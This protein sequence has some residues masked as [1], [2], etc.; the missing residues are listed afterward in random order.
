MSK[1]II[2]LFLA[3]LLPALIFVFLKYFGKNEFDI[4]VYYKD[5]VSE[6]LNGC[7]SIS[8]GQYFVPDS[9]L[10]KW[11]WSGESFIALCGT[12]KEN[13]EL[14]QKM[15]ESKLENIQLITFDRNDGR[16]KKCILIMKD[17][18]DVAL[19]DSQKRIRGYYKLGDR[20]EMDRLEVELKILLKKY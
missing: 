14:K 19:I 6:S 9:I 20:D 1:K 12:E 7:Q 4:P 5:G 10:T 18:W 11:K 2:Y 17:P 8:A 15:I 13:E 3:L 16:T